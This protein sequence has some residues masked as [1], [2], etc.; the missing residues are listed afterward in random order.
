[1]LTW[2]INVFASN[3]PQPPAPATLLKSEGQKNTPPTP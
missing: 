3:P 2:N 1:M